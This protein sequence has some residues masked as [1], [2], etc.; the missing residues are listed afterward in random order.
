MGTWYFIRMR[1][2]A[3]KTL[4]AFYEHKSYQ[5][6]EQ[7]IRAWY[8]IFSKAEFKTPDAIKN[9]FRNASFLSDNRVVFNIHGNK[10]RLIV[11]INYPY[12]VAYVRFIGT[13]SDYDKINATE[14]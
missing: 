5:D 7:P 3:I 8:A 11:K 4:K 10:Y 9:Q 1:V 6:A 13:H 2:I 14:I 12:Q